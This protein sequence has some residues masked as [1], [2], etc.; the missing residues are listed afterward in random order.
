MNLPPPP[1]PF[2]SLRI[3]KPFELIKKNLKKTIDARP[4][5]ALT[6]YSG[7]LAH[8]LKKERVAVES[9]EADGSIDMPRTRAKIKD[10][11]QWR[12]LNR[13]GS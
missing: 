8:S 12:L 6:Y 13:T 1:H 7:L 5:I 4:N 10:Q 9:N 11:V 3:V 2:H